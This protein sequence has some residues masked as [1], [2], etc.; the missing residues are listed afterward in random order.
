MHLQ[1]MWRNRLD[2]RGQRE[3]RLD[4]ARQWHHDHG[5]PGARRHLYVPRCRRPWWD[6]HR[7][8]SQQRTDSDGHRGR[9]RES[10]DPLTL[11]ARGLTL[12]EVVAAAMIVGIGP[13]GLMIVVPIG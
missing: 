3:R 10:D 9:L 1:R 12:A 6:V 2:R 7:Q 4:S 13:A 5:G 11:D 8:S